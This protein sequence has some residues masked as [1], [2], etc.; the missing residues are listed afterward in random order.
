MLLPGANGAVD[1][2]LSQLACRPPGL[3]GPV[4]AV[5]IKRTGPRASCGKE[6]P[7]PAGSHRNFAPPSAKLAP[8][9][10]HAGECSASY[11]ARP[12]PSPP[13]HAPS[14]LEAV[15]RPQKQQKAL[16]SPRACRPATCS[17]HA[18]HIAAAATT[19]PSL[20]SSCPPAPSPPPSSNASLTES[21]MGSSAPSPTLLKVWISW[22]KGG[23]LLRIL[24]IPAVLLALHLEVYGSSPHA[25]SQILHRLSRRLR[26]TQ[27]ACRLARPSKKKQKK[28]QKKKTTTRGKGEEH[29]NSS[30]ALKP[31]T[32]VGR[33]RIM[34]AAQSRASPKT[35]N[36]LS[37]KRSATPENKDRPAPASPISPSPESQLPPLPSLVQHHHL[38]EATDA[39]SSPLSVL[40]YTPSPHL[41]PRLAPLELAELSQAASIAPPVLPL[42]PA[43]NSQPRVKQV[44][45]PRAPQ[46]LVSN[47]A[48]TLASSQPVTAVK[49]IE[50]A[51]ASRSRRTAIPQVEPPHPPLPNSSAARVSLTPKPEP[52]PTPTPA[53]A[54]RISEPPAL[55]A[56]A[57]LP[58]PKPQ[59]TLPSTLLELETFKSLLRSTSPIT[60]SPS[61]RPPPLGRSKSNAAASR[62]S[63]T[64]RSQPH[65]DNAE[66]FERFKALLRGTSDS[67][68][69]SSPKSRP[70]PSP[71]QDPDYIEASSS[72]S[73]PL[74]YT[75]PSTPMPSARSS[76]TRSMS[77]AS[78]V[79]R[80]NNK[81][82][83]LQF[84]IQPSPSFTPKLRPQSWVAAPSPM[85]PS[86]SESS[87]TET[88][89]LA[90][91]AAQE[92][93][94]L[95]LK[96]ELSKAEEDLKM[97][98]NI[99]TNNEIAKQRN[100]TR[101]LT[102]LQPLNTSLANLRTDPGDEDTPTTWLQQDIERKK[103][104]LSSSKQSNKKKVFSGSRHLRTL[105]LLSPDTLTA[106][107]SPSFPQPFDIRDGIDE[108]SARPHT[109]IRH[110]TTPDLSKHNADATHDD[111]FDISSLTNVQRDA[112]LRTGK[113]MATDFK[114]G[115][116]N[117][118]EDIR[119]A[120]VG[121][122]P[123]DSMPSSAKSLVNKNTRKVSAGRPSLNKATSS[124]KPVAQKADA[125]ADDFWKEHGLSEPKIVPV[126]KKTHAIKNNAT[127]QKTSKD[128]EELEDWDNWDTPNDKYS[129]TAN[130]SSDESIEPS[131]P[132]SGPASS[133][134]S[135]RYHSKRHDSKASSLTSISSSGAAEDTTLRENTKRNSIQWPDLVKLSP[136]NLKRTASHLMKEW[137]KT[138][139]PPP[140]S[141]VSDHSSGDY[142]GRSTTPPNLL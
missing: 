98:K 103:A 27:L 93:Y 56:T 104:L 11:F 105:S 75:T 65:P 110:A 15:R 140:E 25:S 5:C 135:T 53:P 18:H 16:S 108:S 85:S 111:Q 99:W 47:P 120:T 82:L 55:S 63:W 131:S 134:T 77:H 26:L 2:E 139:T 126:N 76:H 73:S 78:G 142:V 102:Q 88:N 36:L 101:R 20:L 106:N 80:S 30:A 95:E 91:L 132:I 50:A 114:D 45:A 7:A 125:I 107:Y 57:A 112:I 58:A 32:L 92:R 70:Q 137:E 81:R 66:A 122:D 19:P 123:A 44:E 42:A 124:K 28:N 23:L 3:S 38:A 83:S 115:L 138:L 90:I 128:L 22:V 12:G 40:P 64:H 9:G 34:A 113:K 49:L 35:P 87:Q 41:P 37:R 6:G 61:P 71:L 68:A 54:D 14:L 46:P 79:P 39:P 89:L 10:Q 4:A 17:R 141:R 118:I 84:P 97:L 21:G 74:T 43:P 119:Q 117:F 100:E 109:L 67:P 69:L 116:I 136:G 48:E 96:E 62:A 24:G 133:R 127:P 60:P 129:A 86:V 121:D 33:A 72:V 8:P 94:V 13:A 51:L 1:A 59:P 31:S 130:N 29:A 52:V